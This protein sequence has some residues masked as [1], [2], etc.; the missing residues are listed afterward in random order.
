MRN[1]T[2]KAT[3]T[4]FNGERMNCILEPEHTDLHTDGCCSWGDPW[5]A[6]GEVDVDQHTM[7]LAARLQEE[8][9]LVRGETRV[10]LTPMGYQVTHGTG[11]VKP[12]TFEF[13]TEHEALLRFQHYRDRKCTSCGQPGCA[14]DTGRRKP[15]DIELPP[16][17]DG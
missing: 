6:D 16:S 1:P 12:W 9:H 14:H 5:S 3:S 15:L 8:G 17:I 2:C 7:W 4:E 10:D 11:N 13:S